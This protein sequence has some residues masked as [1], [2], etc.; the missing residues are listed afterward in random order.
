MR[1]GTFETVDGRAAVRFVRE[2]R[3][4]ADAVWAA[5]TEPERLARWFPCDVAF[6]ALAPGAAVTFTFA[7]ED[8]GEVMTGEVL[9]AEPPHRLVFTWAGSTVD[10]AIEP[11][12]QGSRLTFV[13]VLA[14]ADDA[15]RTA[16]GWHVCLDRLERAVA[17]DPDVAAPPATPTPEWEAHYADYTARG[18]PAGAPVPDGA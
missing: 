13:N 8:G 5:V 14:S 11:T 10:L 2:L 16:A 1:H 4:P 15:A 12:P 9:L 3:H 6:D 17:G 18:F 7:P